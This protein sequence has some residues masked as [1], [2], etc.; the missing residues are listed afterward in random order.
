M[1]KTRTKIWGV[2]V[3]FVLIWSSVSVSTAT[4]PYQSP[5]IPIQY[6][7]TVEETISDEQPIVSYVFDATA[8]DQIVA[9]AESVNGDLDPFLTLSTFD[10]TVLAS[11]DNSAGDTNAQISYTLPVADAYVLNVTRSSEAPGN[12]TG[13]FQL[14]LVQGP[15][16]T[17][18][19]TADN[20]TIGTDD[21]G[22]TQ[23]PPPAETS[24]PET[25]INTTD[26]RLQRVLVGST[27]RGTLTANVNFNLYWLIGRANQ[28]IILTPEPSSAFQPLMVLYDNNFTEIFRG[29]P[30]QTISVTLNSDG[31]YFVAAATLRQG[32]GGQYTFTLTERLTAESETTE[33]RDELVYGDSVN[34]A[35][36]NINP[37]I[38]YRFRGGT[39]DAVTISMTSVSGDLDSF[40][41]LVD[42]SGTTIA[43][44]DNSGSGETNAQLIATLPNDGDYFI[45]AT[46]RGQEQGITS[47]NFLLALAS[48][49]PPRPIPTAA[50][51]IPAEYADFDQIHYGDIVEDEIS[52]ALFLN[53]VIFY[54]DVGDRI[55]IEM[56]AVDGNLD[57]FLILLDDQ[58]IP[59]AENDDIVDGNQ[60]SR[61][62]FQLPRD[63]YYAIVATRYQ[64][65][66]G[67]S[68]GN[69]ELTLSRSENT[70]TN[71][72]VIDQL[73][74]TRFTV[75][76]NPSGSFS[77]L[78]F[79]SIYSFSAAEGTQIGF[80]INPDNGT[81]ATVILA[82]S[83]MNYITSSDNG[84]LLA[85][86]APISDD[87]LV[88]VA[89]QSGPAANISDDYFVVL[90]TNTDISPS[91][92]IDGD[93]IPITYGATVRGRI[94]EDQPE[95]R[96]VFQGQAGDIAE[97]SMT[98]EQSSE[99]LDTLLQ[100]EDTDG[101]VIA[102]NDDVEAGVI[103]N[104]FISF[105]LPADGEYTIVAT[106]FSGD[107]EILTV[108]SYNLSLQYQD[109]TLAGI[110]RN[111]TPISYGETLT[112]TID[113]ETYL[114]FYFFEGRQFDNIIIEITT[115]D[116]NLDSILY[117]YTQDSTGEFRLLETNDDS[118]LGG[119]YDPYIAYTLPRT[120]G[121]IIAV[122][123]FDEPAA[124]PT[125][126]TFAISLRL[127]ASSDE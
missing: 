77:P 26:Q 67:T 88:F 109:P 42:A 75:T 79:A 51:Q 115:E 24:V 113:N 30:G 64:Q 65:Q 61:L 81:V 104:S 14:T 4:P 21:L 100:L 40:L 60:N 19:P 103:R 114:Y 122:T 47:G 23:I 54:G 46:R 50:P 69:Y 35:I 44:D 33:D 43:Q 25:T 5:Q 32:N 105:R 120:G 70:V 127:D 22:A 9:T 101:N 78:K 49:A 72:P 20:S 83:R 57:P 59:L 125:S 12:T 92:V 126:G 3:T 98:A 89:P 68:T 39:G 119:T 111:A 11:D 38:R 73:A 123:R 37:T 53:S 31:I 116:N 27:V 99:T 117:L 96:Y 110:N 62:E 10:G 74:P 124:A 86:N 36:S 58:L 91:V 71:E 55:V 56:T 13:L 107:P 18:V 52:N 80:S 45:I 6:G 90:D 34:G 108:G 28:E 94:T 95:I 41:L 29:Q 66:E 48:D 112:D 2:L 85:I 17:T 7:A 8:G 16:P 63:G 102:E 82:D 87:Y 76:E 1:T 97:I 118:P 121:Y 84:I 106:R 93:A 15:P